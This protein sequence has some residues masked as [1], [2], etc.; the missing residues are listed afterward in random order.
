[1]TEDI[2]PMPM[3]PML[4]VTDLAASARF[5]QGALSF[6]LIFTMPGPGGQPALAH[7]RWVKYA[8]LLLARPRDG[9]PVPA[10]RGAGVALSFNLFDRFGGDIAALADH[11]RQHG[12][13]VAGP[14][15]QPWNAR[16]VTV[17]DPD[18]YRLIFTAPID[19]GLAF[20]QVNQRARGGQTT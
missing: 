1:M 19:T 17:L 16:E 4:T 3:F 10:P 15:T 8:D 12:A 18:G 5:Y 11:A 6:K 2:Y 20:D 7:L 9:R 13:H 14:V